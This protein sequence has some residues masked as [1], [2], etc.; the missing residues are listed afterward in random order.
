MFG[1]HQAYPRPGAMYRGCSLT[2]NHP[3]VAGRRWCLA[4]TRRTS[5]IRNTSQGYLADKKHAQ[6]VFGEYQA[7]LVVHGDDPCLDVDGAPFM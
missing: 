7:D 4:S 6:V 1:E 3:P 5:L 2:R